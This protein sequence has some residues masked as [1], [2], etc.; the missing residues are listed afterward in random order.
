[1]F[2]I[3]F[4]IELFV[5]SYVNILQAENIQTSESRIVGNVESMNSTA[6]LELLATLPSSMEGE[7]DVNASTLQPLKKDD[8]KG[9]SSTL[10][11]IHFDVEECR[12]ALAWMIIVDELPF[13]FV[14]GE[15]FRYFVSVV[16]PRFPI[17]SRLSVAR[18]CWDIFTDEKHKLR[19]MFRRGSWKR[20]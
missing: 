5:E 11:A 7:N 9:T 19:S 14:E 18:D 10:A 2:R 3:C 15:E 6:E 8:E 16:Q 12:K 20:L 17:P 1:M 4:V 13:K